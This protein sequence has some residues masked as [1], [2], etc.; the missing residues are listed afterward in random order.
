MQS[1]LGG[2]DCSAAVNPLNGMLKREQV[3]GSRFRDRTDT[4]SSS[5]SVQPLVGGTNFRAT[6]VVGAGFI[7]RSSA[8]ASPSIVAAPQQQQQQQSFEQAFSNAMTLSRSRAHGQHQQ[9]PP[10]MMPSQAPAPALH[11]APQQQQPQQGNAWGGEFQQFAGSGKGK[12][13]EITSGSEPYQQ[14]QYTGYAGGQGQ[15]YMPSFAPGM[16]MNS[17]MGM[18]GMGMGMGAGYAGMQNYQPQQ[19]LSHTSYVPQ[20]QQ[21]VVETANMEEAFERAMKEHE[22]LEAQQQ[23]KPKESEES[24]VQ[25]ALSGDDQKAEEDKERFNNP[26]FEA[27]WQSLKPEA[28]RLGKLAE[29]EKEFSQF[30]NGQNDDG[31]YDFTPD[32]TDA[33]PDF[34]FSSAGNGRLV[35]DDGYPLLGDYEFAQEN[36]HVNDMH[37]LQ[38]ALEILSSGGSLTEACLL[39]EATLQSGTAEQQA[40]T[41]EGGGALLAGGEAAVWTLLGQTQAMDEKETAAV[42]ALEE[43]RKRFEATQGQGRTEAANR[44]FGEGLVSLAISYTNESYD[45]SALLALHRYLSLLHPSYAGPV[46]SSDL[47]LDMLDEES[48]TIP[49]P[50]RANQ[51]LTDSFLALARDQITAGVVD[52]D[53]Q[54]GLGVLYYQTGEFERARDC[55]VAALG[56]RPTD[57]QLWNRLGA[58]LANSGSPEEAIDAYRRAL[59]LKPTFTRAIY[60]LGVSC[61]NIGVYQ[62]AAEHLLAGLA[63]HA[64][65]ASSTTPRVKLGNGADAPDHS[66]TLWTTLRRVFQAMERPDLVDK[67]KAGTDLNVFRQAGFEF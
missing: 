3:D 25:R 35:G 32:L 21:P 61:L 11:Y 42:R 65:D 54:V 19:P 57:F 41:H 9:Q 51:R 53:V 56:V 34:G 52:A 23:A 59:E 1:F 22:E 37:S 63:L 50:W 14:Q 39:L 7:P 16:G 29:W 49:N 47:D 15:G 12:A 24:D 5:R 18:M 6:P 40:S 13:R 48:G 27:V 44:T 55:W 33:V 31:E 64:V 58:T 43:G 45:F 30:A 8:S 36:P 60:N 20:Q 2:A 4:G 62:E 10:M 67:A 46:P 38:R 28:D 17:G 26:D 66:T